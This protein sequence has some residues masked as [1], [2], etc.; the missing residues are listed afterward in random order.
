MVT[1][2]ASVILLDELTVLLLM[3]FLGSCSVSYGAMI[4]AAGTHVLMG[5][6]SQSNPLSLL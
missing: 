5:E 6:Q 2:L 3:K 4:G 1:S